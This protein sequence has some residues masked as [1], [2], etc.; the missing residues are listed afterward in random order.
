MFFFITVLTT[1]MGIPYHCVIMNFMDI[2]DVHH[3]LSLARMMML[4]SRTWHYSMKKWLIDYVSTRISIL[5]SWVPVMCF[6]M[7]KAYINMPGWGIDFCLNCMEYV[8]RYNTQ[9]LH[10]DGFTGDGI[11]H[12]TVCDR[13]E[14]YGWSSMPRRETQQR[15]RDID[16]T[17]WLNKDRKTRLP[18][19]RHI[20]RC[21]LQWLFQSSTDISVVLQTTKSRGLILDHI[22][23]F[24]TDDYFYHLYSKSL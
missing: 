19:I 4:V 12:C 2:T 8:R 17:A 9:A 16:Y 7:R 18:H 22:L 3:R 6:K 23:S 11:V 20:Y 5:N 21:Y 15:Q 1:T 10:R 14:Y 13:V 24:I